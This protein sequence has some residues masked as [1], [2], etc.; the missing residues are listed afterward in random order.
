MTDILITADDLR[1]WADPAYDYPRD[2]DG[3]VKVPAKYWEQ[4]RVDAATAG[5]QLDLYELDAKRA[6]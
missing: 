3:Y 2:Q 4:I 5:D 1:S 6:A